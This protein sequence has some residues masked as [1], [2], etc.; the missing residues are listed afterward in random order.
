MMPDSTLADS[1]P[2]L[3]L[4]HRSRTD[5]N[6]SARRHPSPQMGA[7]KDTQHADFSSNGGIAHCAEWCLQSD[8]KSELSAAFRPLT[9]M[10][11]GD[12]DQVGHQRCAQLSHWRLPSPQHSTPC[13]LSVP[14]GTLLVAGQ[15]SSSQEL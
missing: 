6:V 11:L 2:A 9:C 3:P 7:S 1:T 15:P 5:T 14:S 13:Q 4:V 12:T 8:H 10:C